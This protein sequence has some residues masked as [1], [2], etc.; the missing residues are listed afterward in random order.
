METKADED[1]WKGCVMYVLE[2]PKP[3]TIHIATIQTKTEVPKSSKHTNGMDLLSALRPG[4]GSKGGLL[5]AF[6]LKADSK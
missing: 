6:G 4:G 2:K 5:S 3:E 1:K